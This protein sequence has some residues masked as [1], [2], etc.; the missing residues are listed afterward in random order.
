[1]PLVELVG[2]T[3]LPRDDQ[4]EFEV[5]V[6]TPGRLHAR[7]DGA[8]H[9]AR[10]RN[11]AARA[12]RR[13]ATCSPRSATRAAACAPARATSR[14]ARSTCGSSTC[15]D[16]DYSQF[17]VMDEAR[18]HPARLPR[19]ARERAG[20]Q[21]RS[22]AA[23]RASPTF[24]LNLRG[25]DLEQPAGVRRP[26]DRGDAADARPGRRRHD[27]LAPQAR[28]AARHRPR[29]GHR[30]GRPRAGRRR[31][32]SRR[33]SAGEPV[34]KFKEGDEQYDVWLR[35]DAGTPPHAAGHRRPDGPVA[36]G[37]ARA[38]REP[39]PA[40]ARRP[41]PAQIERLNRQRSITI[42]ANLPHDVPL[43]DAVTHTEKV[44]SGPRP[45][46]ALRHPVAGQ[47]KTLRRDQRTTSCS[48][49][50]CRSSSCT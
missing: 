37:P 23:G 29:A 44:A 8:R 26:A 1:M 31:R 20:H 4:S 30:P 22:P 15:A 7:G 27:A 21:S 12:A 25:P 39:R 38:A 19:P 11:A 16:R 48:P 10:S 41:G 24:E 28:A 40:A 32:R 50:R 3:F 35:A 18:R 17:D 33:S 5:S 43:G 9:A 47:A 49:S 2:K 6:R 42:V 36:H 14:R 45:A 34:S 46:A 13:D